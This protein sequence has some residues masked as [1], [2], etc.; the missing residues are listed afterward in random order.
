MTASSKKILDTKALSPETTNVSPAQDNDQEDREEDSEE[1]DDDDS[2][3]EFIID[4]IPGQRVEPPQ[5][6]GPYSRVTTST[7]GP[8]PSTVSSAGSVSTTATDA[9]VKQGGEAAIDSSNV[10][11]SALEKQGESMGRKGIELDTVGEWNGQPITDVSFDSFED[12]PWRKPG[13]DITDYF[14]Y[15]FDELTWAAYCS[16]Q[17]NL[18]DFNHQKILRILGVNN[19]IS[20]QMMSSGM[21]P[22]FAPPPSFL[23]GFP[24]MMNMGM[25]SPGMPGFTPLGSMGTNNTGNEEG[26][27]GGNVQGVSGMSSNSHSQGHY[28]NQG[29]GSNQNYHNN[30]W[31][32][33]R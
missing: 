1:D 7:S 10:D 21:M 11:L 25:F 23:G 14:N 20:M 2:D 4:A 31:K 18:R 17:D 8:A 24:D 3:I 13:A 12:K 5:K 6:H 32:N 16:R 26:A 19:P 33:N 15:G 28:R 29:D 30:Q 9:L 22:G 27:Y